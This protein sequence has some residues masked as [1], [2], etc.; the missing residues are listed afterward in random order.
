MFNSKIE[1][2]F[3]KPDVD[4]AI[5]S[6]EKIQRM[7]PYRLENMDLYSNLLY[8]RVSLEADYVFLIELINCRVIV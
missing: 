7:D 5:R 2:Q 3:L 8:I 1:S 4:F 6:F